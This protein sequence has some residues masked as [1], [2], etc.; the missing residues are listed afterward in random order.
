MCINLGYLDLF[1]TCVLKSQ[2]TESR[3]TYESQD[4]I[5]DVSHSL[6]IFFTLSMRN[7]LR[8]KSHVCEKA[9]GNYILITQRLQDISSNTIETLLVDFLHSLFPFVVTVLINNKKVN[10]RSGRCIIQ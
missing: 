1:G 2:A 10:S 3:Q 8:P 6:N 7:G 5:Q 9:V 4:I